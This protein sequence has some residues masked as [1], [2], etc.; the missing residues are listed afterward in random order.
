MS[1]PSYLEPTA[2][3]FWRRFVRFGPRVPVHIWRGHALHPETGDEMERGWEW[4]A[5]VGGE[6]ADAMQTWLSC[7][8]NAID[9]PTYDHMLAVQEWAAAY[10]PREPEGRPFEPIDLRTSAPVGP[11]R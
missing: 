7:Y 1:T 8:G 11:P 3:F 6:S 2:G 9:K 10:A 4:R 5:L